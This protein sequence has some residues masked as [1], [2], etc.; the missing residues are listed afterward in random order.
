VVAGVQV[1]PESVSPGLQ[2]YV[3]AAFVA[4]VKQF[5]PESVCPEPHE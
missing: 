2:E 1:E 3:S 4:G 5:V